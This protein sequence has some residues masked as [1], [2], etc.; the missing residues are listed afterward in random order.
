M[1]DVDELDDDL[2]LDGPAGD[3][4][5]DDPLLAQLED[6]LGRVKQLEERPAAAPAASSR[7]TSRGS[8]SSAR[9]GEDLETTIRRVLGE[10]RDRDSAADTLAKFGARL[11]ELEKAPEPPRRG[12]GSYVLG[13]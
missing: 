11:D 10:A 6:L 12:W 13:I 5:G 4:G 7:R 3:E 1:P 2:D 9:P 8:T